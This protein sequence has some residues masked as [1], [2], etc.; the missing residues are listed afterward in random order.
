MEAKLIEL[1]P[2]KN[3]I[4]KN[5]LDLPMHD[6]VL[7]SFILDMVNR[8]NKSDS[9]KSQYNVLAKHLSEFSEKN[10][11]VIYTNSITEEFLEDFIYYLQ[12]KNMRN[13]T[14]K[15]LIEKVKA[16][17]KKAGNYGYAVNRTFD[18]VSV[19]EEETC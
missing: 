9:Y 6:K 3:Y 7:T 15:G 1:K 10:N 18:E 13:N 16:I 2:T 5:H 14:V 11:C 4:D 17:T 8:K 12:D 19:Q